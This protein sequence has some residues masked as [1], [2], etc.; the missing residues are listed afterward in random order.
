MRYFILL[1]MCLGLVGC[2]TSLLPTAPKI[3]YEGETY[4]PFQMVS[5]DELDSSY[6][7]YITDKLTGEVFDFK[8]YI[9]LYL[10]KKDA[11]FLLKKRKYKK[12]SK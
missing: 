8:P 7:W 10:K 2:R 9:P 4:V 1:V 6:E 12:E 11:D 5:V 3:I